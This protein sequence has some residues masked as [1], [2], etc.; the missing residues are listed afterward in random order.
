MRGCEPSAVVG[1]SID[2]A[3]CCAEAKDAWD[4]L[5]SYGPTQPL[6][7][8]LAFLPFV[9]CNLMNEETMIPRDTV[10]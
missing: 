8:E 2:E 7:A 1:V 6:H 4:V 3:V 5:L 9:H 10:R